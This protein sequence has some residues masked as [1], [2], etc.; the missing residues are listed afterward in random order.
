MSGAAEDPVPALRAEDPVP[1]LR[2][3]GA[4][5]DHHGVRY[6][7]PG[8]VLPRGGALALELPGVVA[9][10]PAA[11]RA[12]GEDT[13][14]TLVDDLGESLLGLAPL[15]RGEVA[16]FGQILA[17]QS[18]TAQLAL[19]RRVAHAPL[20][21]AFLSTVPVPDNVAIPR[22]D[23]LDPPDDAL[24]GAVHTKLAALEVPIVGR[25]L[26]AQLTPRRRYLAGVA[27]ALL[28]E[29]DLL[30]LGLPSA[31]L[32]R[33]LARKLGAELDA[34]RARGA[35]ILLLSSAGAPRHTQVE[36]V[37]HVRRLSRSPEPARGS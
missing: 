25:V 12:D 3:E 22:R 1:A 7:I 13:E 8:F 31:D 19:R 14:E 4:E 9:A 36:G 28:A 37:L 16:L 10:D 29:P 35:A 34:T 32:P 15:A 21:P 23:R 30:V 2:A 6:V 24:F 20:R 33:E 5:F 17:R 26:P 18:R 27:R 11:P